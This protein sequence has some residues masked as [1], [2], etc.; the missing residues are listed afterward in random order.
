MNLED[1]WFLEWWIAWR[2]DCTRLNCVVLWRL[3]PWLRKILRIYCTPNHPVNH[4][5]WK[6][7]IMTFRLT[8][9][10]KKMVVM[11]LKR[12][13][14]NVLLHVT[15]SCILGKYIWISCRVID[16]RLWIVFYS[17][18]QRPGMTLMKCDLR[19]CVRASCCKR[20]Q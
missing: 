16:S 11:S 19:G 3:W 6:H 17:S 7:Y 12:K 9:K 13:K 8:F 2:S 1:E 4:G 14:E 5:F 18:C 15:R 20:V 10:R